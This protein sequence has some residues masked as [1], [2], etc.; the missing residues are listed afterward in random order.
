MATKKYFLESCSVLV[1]KHSLWKL[2]TESHC[3]GLTYWLDTRSSSGIKAGLEALLRAKVLLNSLPNI[4]DTPESPL[5][6][7]GL[8]G[9]QVN[10]GL[11]GYWKF[12]YCVSP[13]LPWIQG[14]NS[15]GSDQCVWMASS[16]AGAI[17]FTRGGSLRHWVWRG[18]KSSQRDLHVE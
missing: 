4:S 1:G 11:K 7:H 3:L 9:T 10:G 2:S 18:E 5:I 12:I 14:L 17:T 8:L 15:H 6:L 16:E 13:A